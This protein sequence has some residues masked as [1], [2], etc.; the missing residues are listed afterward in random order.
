ASSTAWARGARRREA[1]GSSTSSSV[2]RFSAGRLRAGRVAM[3]GPASRPSASAISRSRRTVSTLATSLRRTERRTTLSSWPVASWKRRLS[4]SRRYSD[5]RFSSSSSSSSRSSD[6]VGMARL[7]LHLGRAVRARADHEA[8]LEG[9]LLDGSLHGFARQV[10]I[11][12][13]QFEQDPS[14]PHDGD[15]VLGIPL[16]RPHARLGRLL[17]HGLVREGADPHLPASLDVAG[18]GDSSGLDLALG[19]PPRL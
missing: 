17:G 14:G 12:P 18:H 10:A 13:G 15:P 6:A 8:G 16:A 19:E 4:I 2:S 11:D 7:H 5:S 9:E 3:T 1:A